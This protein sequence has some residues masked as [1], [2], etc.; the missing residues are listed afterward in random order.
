M[1]VEGFWMRRAFVHWIRAADSQ[2]S[3][4]QLGFRTEESQHENILDEWDTG[5][6]KDNPPCF[7][8]MVSWLVG[9]GG[10]RFCQI[11]FII[12]DLI[13]ELKDWETGKFRTKFQSLE[14][15]K[16]LNSNTRPFMEG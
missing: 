4:G 5:S 1:C 6:N 13:S 10:T 7:S 3:G 12:K 11:Q 14:E 16:V 8:F 15:T 2:L 9:K